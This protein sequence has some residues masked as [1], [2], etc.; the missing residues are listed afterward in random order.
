MKAA[1][2][3]SD[4][5]TYFGRNRPPA[6][7]G[8][9]EKSEAAWR[10]ALDRIAFRH[11]LQLK[12]WTRSS[13][14]KSRK[15]SSGKGLKPGE[16]ARASGVYEIVGAR[17]GLTGQQVVVEHGKPLPPIPKSAATYT[18]RAKSGRYIITSPAR[19]DNTVRTW[20]RAFKKK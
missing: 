19:S 16:R 2:F 15:K 6:A 20:S 8:N 3:I 17:G 4:N 11:Y 14:S 5:V 10:A 13:M 18:L 7:G 9:V 1:K 12:R